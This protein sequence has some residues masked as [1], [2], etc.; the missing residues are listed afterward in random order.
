[1]KT[2]LIVALAAVLTLSLVACGGNGGSKT[3][4]TFT[5]GCEEL[6]GT[7]S[8]IYYS[9]S[10]DG[11]VVNLVYDALYDYD[12]DGVLQPALA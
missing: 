7:F 1:M 11:Y 3:G 6:S 12:Y 10:Y 9:S 8:P 5:V 4:G 2:L